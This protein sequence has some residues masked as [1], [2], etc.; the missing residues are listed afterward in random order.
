LSADFEMDMLA[1]K[2][3]FAVLEIQFK[4]AKVDLSAL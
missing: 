4:N 3:A 2:T 1:G